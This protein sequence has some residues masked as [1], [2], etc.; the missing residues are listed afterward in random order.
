MR[1]CNA[2]AEVDQIFNVVTAR[3]LEIE[4][5]QMRNALIAARGAR[6]RQLRRRRLGAGVVRPGADE[7]E[8][9]ALMDAAWELG[10]DH[11]DTADAYGGGRSE[12]AIGRWIASRGRPADADDQDVQP[13]GARARD[14]GLAPERI[15][16]QLQSSLER[17]GVDRVEL[18]LAHEFDPDTRAGRDDRG[19]RG[20]R[21]PR[22]GSAAYGVSNFD[23]APARAGARRRRSPSA[24]QN[25][26]SL[27]E[28]GDEA[29]VVAVCAR[30]AGR[31]TSVVQP[32]ARAAG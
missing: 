30:A 28:R 23:A 11:F 20:A 18:Y 15:E 1:S 8:A 10:I 17:L 7:D 24:V 3:P 16:R 13:D 5:R 22:A 21:R 29:D 25:G 14:Q 31:A 26:Y 6:L 32:A 4:T 27:L 9:F 2:A 12:R 19:V